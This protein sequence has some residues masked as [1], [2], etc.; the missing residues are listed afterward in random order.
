[1]IENRALHQ[2]QVNPKNKKHAQT[3]R[4]QAE[5]PSK[6]PSSEQWHADP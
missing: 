3:G 4:L 1:M 5:P 2:E 6:N